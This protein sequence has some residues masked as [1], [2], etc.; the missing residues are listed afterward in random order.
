MRSPT[1]KG[2]RRLA[3]TSISNV[4]GVDDAPFEREFRGDVPI[5]GTVLS[6]TRLDGVLLSK[7][8]RDGVNST[9]KIASMVRESPFA[10]HIGAVLLQGIALAGFN[11]VDIERLHQTLELPVLVVAR[12]TPRMAAIR[13]AL[14]EKVP[15]GDKKWALIQAAGPVED[16]GGV[17][18][19]R[20]G[21]TR[22]EARELLRRTTLHGSLP[23]A[24]RTAHL[25]A[26]GV[27]TG[28]SRGRA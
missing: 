26:G 3:S 16:V 10:G 6:R 5:V 9:E 25:I 2:R 19:Q 23:E 24:L 22:Q 7:V 11:V 20:R 1:S 18:V 27:G 17:F 14:L 4:L 21:L 28:V 15:G 8:R 13:R 12:R